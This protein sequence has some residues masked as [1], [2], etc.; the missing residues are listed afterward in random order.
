MAWSFRS[1]RWAWETSVST[2]REAKSVGTSS[3]SMAV[4]R[5]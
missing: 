2:Q 5:S 4:G 1:T 3:L